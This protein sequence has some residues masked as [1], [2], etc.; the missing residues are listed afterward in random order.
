MTY[1]RSATD[2]D[3]TRI[4][5]LL[6]REG[7]PTSDLVSARPEFVVA[8]EGEEVLGIGALQRFGTT[9]LLRSVAVDAARRGTGLGRSIVQALEDHAR[10]Q[11]ITNL[12]L[13]TQT[14]QRFFERQG[15]RVVERQSAPSAVQS[16]EEFRSLC[17]ASAVCMSKVLR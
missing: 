11:G 13:L 3:T 1:F 14:A 6:E 15:Y 17:P 16:S 5:T 10:K 8:C 4:R 2:A 9:A 12:V 7:L